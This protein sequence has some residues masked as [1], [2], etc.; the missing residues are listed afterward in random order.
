MQQR[1]Q[2][3]PVE[4]GNLA[5]K[6]T[7]P[8]KIFFDLKRERNG[9]F[10]LNVLERNIAVPCPAFFGFVPFLYWIFER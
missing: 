1:L 3:V 7:I 5:G 8:F 10:S 6:L 9:I 2:I 4:E